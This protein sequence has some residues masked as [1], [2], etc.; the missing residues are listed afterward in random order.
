MNHDIP[1]PQVPEEMS[2]EAYDLVDKWEL[3]NSYPLPVLT[4]QGK[5]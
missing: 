3:K 5:F 4:I 1:W 2:Y